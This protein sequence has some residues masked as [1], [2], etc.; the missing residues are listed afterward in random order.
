MK[1]LV[2][3]ISTFWL[4]KLNS[5]FKNSLPICAPWANYIL[6]ELRTGVKNFFS[7]STVPHLHSWL[8]NSTAHTSHQTSPAARPWRDNCRVT[9][10]PPQLCFLTF[11][12][13][14]CWAGVCFQ[15]G[16]KAFSHTNPINSRGVVQLFGT[17]YRKLTPPSLTKKKSTQWVLC[18]QE[19]P[20]Y[21]VVTLRHIWNRTPLP[22]GWLN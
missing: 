9:V 4:K 14:C 8:H 17:L 15:Q 6:L 5:C 11:T 22:N 3:L 10:I 13:N 12:W 20:R 18:V 7:S 2:K 1:H 21:F 16:M 19:P